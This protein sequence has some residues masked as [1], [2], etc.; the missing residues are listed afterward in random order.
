MPLLELQDIRKS[1]HTTRVLQGVSFTLEA[2]EVH[3]LVGANGAGKSTLIKI[4]AGAYTRDGGEIRL[5]G[6]AV[7]IRT[8][9]DALELG[10]GV[11][12]QEFNLVPELS[13]AEN[14]LLGQEPARR[15]AGVPLLSRRALREE[16]ARHLRE[17]GFPLDPARAVKSLTTGEKQ[18]VEIAK[19]LH[20]RARVLVLD[21][22]TAALS[23]AETERLF[24]LMGDLQQRGI[25][26]IYI[27]H[28]LEEVF[29]V[30]DRITV[31]RDGRAVAT[32]PRGQVTEQD[33]VQAMVG[34]EVAAGERRGAEAGEV[35]LETDSL[36]GTGFR[37]VS[38]RVRRGEILAITGAAGAGQ[39]DLLW[40]LYGASPVAGGTLRVRGEA[41]R[42]RSLRDAIRGGVLMA[43][44]DRKAYGILPGL[45]VATNFTFA[46]LPRWSIA[47]VL[48]RGAQREAAAELIR[49]YGVRCSGPGQ[50][51]QSLSGGNQ[52][53]V[54]IGRVTERKADVYLFDEPTRGV[55]IGA[56]EEI[57]A[58]IHRLAEEG[59]GIVVATPDLQEALRLGDRIAVMR[60]GRLVHEAVGAGASEH[61]LVAAI[62]GGERG[63]ERDGERG[64]EREGASGD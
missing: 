16:A 40:A 14:V 25:G 63:G 42:W 24:R 54:V 32:W 22:P 1:F 57:Y 10:I 41:R 7:S 43:P 48:K 62:I 59:A 3:A 45:D 55:D 13:V 34:R 15:V 61:E 39:T 23:R 37:E 2:G 5:D 46:D 36:S 21:E 17:L 20:R 64:F 49:R 31:L 29:Q 27:S 26:M 44:G 28:H 30:G 12:Y 60:G 56:R 38:L 33:L 9:Q 4:L 35:V 6:R 11:I 18:L 53:K 47:G 50:E 51:M 58:L 8:P 19:A 52:Q